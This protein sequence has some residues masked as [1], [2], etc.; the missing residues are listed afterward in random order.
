MVALY[1]QTA[2]VW[3]HHVGLVMATW[4]RK[5]MQQT[6]SNQKQWQQQHYQATAVAASA[7]AWCSSYDHDPDSK[8]KCF[9][10]VT[11]N[12]QQQKL[13]KQWKPHGP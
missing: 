8:Q 9:K 11:I 12:K 2:L 3:Q 1:S 4:N 13:H 7:S 6:T 5:S 10:N